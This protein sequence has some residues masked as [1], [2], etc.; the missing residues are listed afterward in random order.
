VG[1]KRTMLAGVILMAGMFLLIILLNSKTALPIMLI[2]AGI[3]WAL[4]NIN[5]Y[6]TIVQMAP[7]GETGKYTGFYYAFSFSASIV[8]PILFGFIADLMKSYRSLFY[9]GMV[10][11]LLAILTLSRVKLRKEEIEPTDMC[12]LRLNEEITANRQSKG[13][14]Q[15]KRWAQRGLPD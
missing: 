1:S 14:C 11:F 4:I 10:M 13:K 5:S 9:Y 7:K 3:G 12:W 15:I 6:P 8:S 2:G